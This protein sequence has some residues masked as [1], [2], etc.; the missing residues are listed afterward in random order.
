MNRNSFTEL[1]KTWTIDKLLDIVENPNDYQPL[2]I[3]TARHELESRQLSAEQLEKAKAIQVER[4]TERANKQQKTNAV[5]D[6][7][8][9][10]AT[11]L[12]YTFSPIQK[13]TPTARKYIKLISLFL[14]GLSFYEIYKNIEILKYI[15]EDNSPFWDLGTVLFFLPL[16]YVPT[17]GLLLWFRKKLGWV[18]SILFFFYIATGAIQLFFTELKRQPIRDPVLVTIFPDVSLRVYVWTF[19][20]FSGLI[21]VMTKENIREIYN[22]DERTLFKTIW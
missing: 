5:V 10:I 1:Y 3:E 15:F 11:T 6:K 14:G 8:K 2:A 13:G 16:I 20:F 7:I 19:L 4:Q 12:V 22:I 9:S 18:L 21:W 17:A